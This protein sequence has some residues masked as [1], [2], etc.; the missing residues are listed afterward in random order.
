MAWHGI[1]GGADLPIE[2]CDDV[3]DIFS[4]VPGSNGH[5]Y[6]CDGVTGDQKP[7]DLARL[8]LKSGKIGWMGKFETQF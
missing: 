5:K 2:V 6:L 4:S 8:P 1:H 7:E 3:F